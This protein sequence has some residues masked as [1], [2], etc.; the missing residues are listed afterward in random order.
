[1]WVFDGEEWTSDEV[2]ESG[3]PSR[4]TPSYP[5]E[6]VPEVQIIEIRPIVHRAPTPS[7]SRDKQRPTVTNGSS[8]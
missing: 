3:R 4:I 7:V 8:H 2:G 6:F 5:G 1:M